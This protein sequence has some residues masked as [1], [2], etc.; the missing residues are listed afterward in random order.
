MSR[1]HDQGFLMDMTRTFHP[2][3]GEAARAFLLRE[4]QLLIDG[5]AAESD[6]GRRTDIVDPATGEVIATAAEGSATDVD[7]AGDA[8][9][10][11]FAGPWSKTT[12]AARTRIMLRFAELIEAH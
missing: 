7:R 1:T 10:R 6:S 5:R 2:A 9:R 8:A 12:P 4:H 11:A 3:L